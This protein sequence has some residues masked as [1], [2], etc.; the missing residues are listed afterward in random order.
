ME[1]PTTTTIS[2]IAIRA[3]KQATIVVALLKVTSFG[4]LP[5]P[6]RLAA[7]VGVDGCSLMCAR[8]L[9]IDLRSR[10][11]SLYRKSIGYVSLRIDEMRPRMLDVGE[12]ADQA[13]ALLSVHEDLMRRLRSKEDQVEELLARADNLVTEQQEPDVLVYEAMAE[14][15]G[16]AWKELNRQLQMRG[17]LLKEALRFYEYAEQHERLASR[18]KSA[19][20]SPSSG[21]DRTNLMKQTGRDVND[22]IGLTASAVDSGADIITQIR[23]L[24]AMADN[25]ERAQETADACLLVE[26]TMLK[27]AVEWEQIEE[28]WKTERVK[29]SEQLEEAGALLAQIDEIEQ[30]LRNARV[31]FKNGYDTNSLLQQAIQQR[32]EVGKLMPELERNE[33]NANLAGRAA[34]LY[35]DIE[36]FIRDI[37]AR[38]ADLERVRNFISS[39]N[40]MLNQLDAM[41]TDMRNANAAMAGELA[42]LA[43]QKA[44][45][46]IEDGRLLINLDTN[47]SRLVTELEQK[48]KQIERLAQE[49]ISAASEHFKQELNRI[50]SWISN[51]AEPFLPAHGRMGSTPL[52]ANEFYSSHKNF[53]TEIVNKE[54]ELNAILNRAHELP[55]ADRKRLYL[56]Q[57]RFENL[58]QVVESRLRLGNAFQQVHKFAK[59]LEG[60]FESLDALLSTSRNFTNEKLISQMTEV[61][62]MVQETLSQERHQGEKFIA[63]VK[64]AAA[65]DADLHHENAIEWVHSMLNEHERRFVTVNEHWQRWQDNRVHEQKIMHIVEEVQM[66]QEETVEIV[67]VLE[68]K[69]KK[70]K[71]ATEREQLKL[72]MDE[73]IKELPKQKEKIVEAEE[74][75]KVSESDEAY[76]RVEMAKRKH[77]DLEERI[78]QLRRIVET[79][80][81]LSVQEAR[82]VTRAPEIITQLRDAQVDEGCRF[83]FAARVE[84]EPTPHIQWLKDGRDVKDNVDYRQAYTNGVA[85]LTIE[86]T[87]VEDTA[88]YTVRAENGAGKAES[89]AQL[90]VK[91]RSEMGSQFEE[92][93]KPRFVRQLQNVSVNEGEPARLDC[94]VVGFPEPKVVWYKEEE[95]VKESE[96]ITLHFE[97]DHCSLDINRT[98][99]ADSGLYTAKASNGFGETTNF[100]RLTVTP[101]MRAAPPPTPP[102]PRPIAVAPSFLPP[103]INQNLQEGQRCMFQVRVLGEPMPRVQWSFD[104]RAIVQTTT[105]MK[106]VEDSNGWSRL[107]IESVRPEHSGMYTIVA[108]NE[109]GEA[110]SGATL[111]V[112]P[113][114][115]T[116]ALQEKIV[117]TSTREGYWSDTFM[118]SP[119]PPPVPKHR[120]RSDIEEIETSGNEFE[121]STTATAPEFIRP[122]QNEYT[123][124]EGE[125]FKIDC[126][127]VGNPRPKVHWYFNDSI[128]NINSSFCKFSNIGDTYSIIFE[129]AQLENAG[130]YKMTAEN[131]RGKTES[132]TILHVRPKSIQQ[133][134]IAK[135]P[136]TTEHVQVTEE[137]GA[138]EYEQRA[139][140][141]K[142]YMQK[143]HIE[144]ELGMY[145]EEERRIASKQPLHSSQLATPPPAKKQQLQTTHERLQLMHEHYDFEEGRSKAA[146][147]PPHFTQTLV[148]AVAACGD[149]T[150]FEGVV[151]AGHPPHFTQTLVSAVAACGDSTKFEG[152]VTGWPVPEVQWT[153]DGVPVSKATNPE[154]VFSNIGGRVSLS[155]PNAQLEHAGKYMCTAKNASG[156]ATSSAQLVVRPK[157]IAPDF[158]RRL[159]SEEVVE[160]DRLTWTVQVTGDP[161]PK[162]TWLRDAQVIP[163]CDEVRLTDEGNGVYSMIIMKV[164]MVDCGQFT[165]L[166]ENVAGEARSTADLVVRPKGSEPG[167]Y[168]HVTKVTQE[169]QVKGEEVNRNQ[170][171]SIENPRATP[172]A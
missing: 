71:M 42:P 144:E 93:G 9:S 8:H 107:I 140:D 118:S 18:I 91:S 70:S 135:K 24:G 85:T 99:P 143:Q 83:E 62:R 50:E 166:A 126:L 98:Q 124:T 77:R 96:R 168:F 12:N 59:E 97:G 141:R 163:N 41:E 66:W 39:A 81:Q 108:E 13:A 171:F 128:I 92:E 28:S 123:V 78:T 170:T 165:C 51:V 61:F 46:L 45:V 53:F 52:E 164:E 69:A 33:A 6:V 154:L 38:N 169:K 63:S 95:T 161:V 132:L 2:T 90:I 104:D 130:Y 68:A 55:E 5:I 74:I 4:T 148:S 159:I 57:S 160:G 21:T 89:S 20:R 112:E 7:N 111:N 150:K 158:V 47:V 26:K 119:T 101:M 25:V 75:T 125:K 72:K 155:F 122:F 142:L 162:V 129:P 121:F 54:S 113:K 151:T 44:Q 157:T 106:V 103:L 10:I 131:I 134:Q 80:E 67:R 11:N 30:W 87:F 82:E 156:V 15:L 56:F 22:L 110:R 1:R 64:S 88:T 153:K 136:I 17:Y 37:E 149:S 35:N 120:Y 147:H 48:L 14:S 172:V 29:M 86:E 139:D 58:K 32:S 34:Q 152:V 94:V 49:R 102:K 146:G 73:V 43:R 16:S 3:G 84:G 145:E 40:S 127:M 60:S 19:L 133:Q 137:F 31:Q 100:C 114:P 65:A 27:M 36:N 138:F 115:V 105:E 23:V 76:E 79:Q 117:T 109:A 116:T 167:N